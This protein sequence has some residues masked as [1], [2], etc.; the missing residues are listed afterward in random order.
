MKFTTVLTLLAGVVSALPVEVQSV[1]GPVERDAPEVRSAAEIQAAQEA[2][3]QALFLSRNEVVDGDAFL[4][5][6]ELS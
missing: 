6:L 5:A 2:E 3:A 4:G 1:D